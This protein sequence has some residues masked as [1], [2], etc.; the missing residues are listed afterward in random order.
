MY[1]K[2]YYVFEKIWHRRTLQ[3]LKE[4]GRAKVIWVLSL[5]KHFL[6]NSTKLGK[7]GRHKKVKEISQESILK[8]M[9]RLV[10]T[11]H[12]MP[13]KTLKQ[14]IKQN[15][16]RAKLFKFKANKVYWGV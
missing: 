8:S 11:N 14:L 2:L 4:Q 10:T 5:G 12:T 9:G 7:R 3:N 1:H 15:P 6:Q 16:Y 13:Y